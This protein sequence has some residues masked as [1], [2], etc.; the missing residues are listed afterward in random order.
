MKEHAPTLPTLDRV[1]QLGHTLYELPCQALGAHA[2]QEGQ[3]ILAG[4]AAKA[5][6]LVPGG[7]SLRHGEHW[8]D[9]K[10][11]TNCWTG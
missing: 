10:G 2:V 7:S 6:D 11:I 4:L 9:S 5:G 1:D 8:C 3:H